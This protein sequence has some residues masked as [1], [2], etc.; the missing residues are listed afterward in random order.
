MSEALLLK[1]QKCET[2]VRIREDEETGRCEACNAVVTRSSR[3]PSGGATGGGPAPRPPAGPQGE[4][5]GLTPTVVLIGSL[6]LI[7]AGAAAFRTFKKGG[8]GSSP[9]SSGE[10]VYVPAPVVAA[11][12]APAGEIAWETEALAPVVVAANA[13]GVEDIF[14]FFRVWDGRSAWTSHG[15]VFDGAT[16]RP[17][18]RSDPIDPQIL[19]RQGIVPAA[20]PVGARIIV[21][22]ATPTLR[23]FEIASGNKIAS[24]QMADVVVNMCK[25]PDPAARI[26]VQ[27]AGDQHA[28][29]DLDTRKATFAPRPAWCSL[30]E[31]P[32]REGAARKKGA[33]DAAPPS[34]ACK[35]DF[36]NGIARAA[37]APG[38]DAPPID[39]VQNH[40]MLKNGG[41]AVV[42]AT[43]DDRPIAIGVG[44]GYKPSWATPLVADDT[45]PRPEAPHVA[46]LVDGK[47]YAV[48]AK[49][50]FDARLVA[51]DASTGARIWDVPLVGSMA[52]SSLGDLGRGEARSLAASKTRVYVTRSGGGLDVFDATDGKAIGTIGKK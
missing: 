34:Q 41:A 44:P 39:G 35:D 29:V 11:K 36:R 17:L 43:K 28:L 30:P 38:D 13:D 45:K 23:V 22:D 40:Y 3:E 47:L 21:S 1:C 42:L 33:A 12:E 2:R 46:E 9:A 32:P 19:K 50:Y 14:G 52:S 15:G 27:V 48:F 10:A 16:L 31:P 4:A 25:A 8:V 49:V 7:V 24:L 26:W 18:W 51:L 6:L 5:Q 37:C 20:L